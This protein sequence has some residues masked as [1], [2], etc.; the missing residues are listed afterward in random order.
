[1]DTD[2]QR[3]DGRRLRRRLTTIVA[4]CS[5]VAVLTGCSQPEPLTPIPPQ[6]EATTEP[7]PTSGAFSAP[8]PTGEKEAI[9]A[10]IGAYGSFLATLAQ[11]Y[12]NPTDT[13]PIFEIAAEPAATN[14][15]TMASKL[16]EAGATAD[17]SG[18]TFTPDP[19][20]SR[21]SS[22]T[23]A[24]GNAFDY[25]TV[26]LHGCLDGSARQTVYS[27][28]RTEPLP[29]PLRLR[30]TVGVIF[31]IDQSRWYVASEQPEGEGPTPC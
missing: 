4:V 7:T 19:E 30:V 8:A 21:A 14:A 6:S 31:D 24:D 15:V 12:G 1:M 5:A 11:V 16:A 17:F 26:E 22:I 25:G 3:T 18:T 13:S 28:G 9:D 2:T 29:E 10:A 20:L 23:N 27:N